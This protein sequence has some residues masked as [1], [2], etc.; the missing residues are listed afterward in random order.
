[1][2]LVG[3]AE[4]P[5]EAGTLDVLLLD[6][7]DVVPDGLDAAALRVK[8][9]A[10]ERRARVRGGEVGVEAS[11]DVR[12]ALWQRGVAPYVD[13]VVRPAAGA[14]PPPGVA[15]WARATAAASRSVAGALG[16][17]RRGNGEPV[18]L[19][20][21]AE[22]A[23]ALHALRETLPPGLT[24]LADV[25]VACEPVAP[26]GA[27]SCA[28][29]VFLH[30]VTLEAVALVRPLVPVAAV[31]AEP[32]V[33]AVT[34][35]PLAGPPRQVSDADVERR[36]GSARVTLP[37]T[38]APFVLRL[39]GWAGEGG[40]FLAGLDVVDEKTL[41]VD[42]VI[43]RHQ[44]A[45]AR[46]R[47]LVTRVIAHGSSVLAFQAPGLAAPVTVTADTVLFTGP[48]GTE[49]EQR[50][51]RLNGAELVSVGADGV[52]RLPIVEPER[53]DRAPL[54][55]ALD[56]AYRY[57]LGGRERVDGR[58]AYVV[59]FEPRDEGRRLFR[60]RAWIDARQF[61][62]RRVDAAQT[63]LRGAIVSSE[64]RD[65]FVPVALRGETVWLLGRSE[66][67]QVYEGAGHRTPIQRVMTL[68]RHEVD[69]ADYDARLRAAHGSSSV[70]LRE[71][72]EGLRY[73]RKP[74]AREAGGE[75][76]VAPG[77]ASSVRTLAMGAIV[78]PNISAPL[79]FAGLSYLD[80]DFLGTGAQVNAF[81]AAAFVQAAAAVPSLGGT[82][83]QLHASAFATLAEYNDRAFRAGLEQYP[84]NLRQR[85]ARLSLALVRPLS[86]RW[87]AR[88]GYELDYTRL[89][90]SDLTAPQFAVPASPLV[91][92]L[93]LSLEGQRGPWTFGAWWAPARRASW[94]AWGFAEDA[95][96]AR[97]QAG[98]QRF[99]LSGAR[100]MVVSPRVLLRLEAAAMAGTDLDRFSR[101]SFDAFENRLRGYPS[102]GLRFDRGLVVRSAGTWN[103][104]SGVRLDVFADTAFA[105]DPGFGPR[106]RR[107]PGVGA[108]LEAP[109]PWRVLAAAEWG[110][111]FEGRDREGGR[112][113]HVFRVTAY[114]VF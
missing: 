34:V 18:L 52:P 7:R 97:E 38:E 104:A 100:T 29:E 15:S 58:D 4:P 56:E 76:V 5:D 50:R 32:G 96:V 48:D 85:P 24:P 45:A 10:T 57:R 30:P 12:A 87:R 105:R 44:A 98:F 74:P 26:S 16:A 75:R 1:W 80:F 20:W 72:P 99:G 11:E 94:R 108:G 21:D 63:A 46:Q 102:A 61:A 6:A 107:Y 36:A 79:P 65:E 113:T 54:T 109:L 2:P 93:R 73:L 40:R 35:Q 55:I 28:A 39:S 82:R 95:D 101:F 3:G 111:G 37:A 19:P 42:E 106:L 9:L 88:V 60:G 84:E 23:P 51:I 68:A 77:R 86:A 67:N 114:K 8:T 25:A 91:H 31:R 43:A 41:T 59:H 78:D 22:A 69:P 83:V 13:F 70:M 27:A 66:V 53:A 92:A 112:G 103:V 81:F 33:L 17:T 90:R 49:I 64:Q 89:R 14:A 71:T 62:M 47:H 110:Y